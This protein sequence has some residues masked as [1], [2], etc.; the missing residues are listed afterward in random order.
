VTIVIGVLCGDFS[1]IGADTRSVQQND[2]GTAW[3]NDDT[4][5]K[6]ASTGIGVLSG[7]GH[8]GLLALTTLN[9]QDAESRHDLRAAIDDAFDVIHESRPDQ[10]DDAKRAT[11]FMYSYIEERS[12]VLAT[13]GPEDDYAEHRVEPFSYALFAPA[14]MP[15]EIENALR[16]QIQ[17]TIDRTLRGSAQEL[18]FRMEQATRI[19]Q[20][21]IQ[22]A[23]QHLASVSPR[24]YQIGILHETP[25]IQI[26][27]ITDDINTIQLRDAVRP[28]GH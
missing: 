16:T 26:S 25:L 2:E 8:W 18:K 15:D 12:V 22:L 5:E 7:A 11:T 20:A 24:T 27:E 17:E 23:G 13:V 10:H 19:I 21:A 4:V 28:F 9:M 14:G 3:I 6:V 1:V